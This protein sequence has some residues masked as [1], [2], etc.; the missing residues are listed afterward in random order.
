[1]DLLEQFDAYCERTDFSF[2][3]EPVNAITNFAF[4]IAAF[5]A[6]QFGKGKPAMTGLAPFMVVLVAVI[7]TG[8]FLFHTYA[9]AWASLADVIP[10]AIYIFVFFGLAMRRMV[11]HTIL[12]S[13]ILTIVFFAVSVVII[14][15][16][17][18]YVGSSAGYVPALL[19]LF[20][21][22]WYLITTSRIGGMT[23]QIAGVVFLFSLTARTLDEPFCENFPLGLHFIW[24]CL[25]AVVLYTTLRALLISPP[26]G[27][28]E[29]AK[30]TL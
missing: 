17:A 18:P 4:I 27:R 28:T 21:V 12:M 7:G 26:P 11:G 30:P 2:W 5:G 8:S 20:G 9:T 29:D 16:S 3:S 10:I 23:L 15:L 24:H 25:N 14:R 19:A 6:W 22:G 1:M 13:V